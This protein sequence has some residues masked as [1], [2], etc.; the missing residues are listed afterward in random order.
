MKLTCLISV[1]S[2][3]DCG[4]QWLKAQGSERPGSLGSPCR[5]NPPCRFPRRPLSPQGQP[6][7][8]DLSTPQVTLVHHQG[9]GDSLRSWPDSELRPPLMQVIQESRDRSY[10]VGE[11][12]RQALSEGP[13]LLILTST[14][15]CRALPNQQMLQL[16]LWGSQM[17]CR[18]SFSYFREMRFKP[19]PLN[20]A[21][22]AFLNSP[23]PHPRCLTERPV[24]MEVSLVRSHWPHAAVEHLKCGWCK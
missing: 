2:V 6:W 1:T 11:H 18:K 5:R 22:P 21:N 3:T 23:E 9:K 24:M 12:L 10:N 15:S 16:S 4:R 19:R 13:S 14:P 7:Q 20:S 17:T 8:S